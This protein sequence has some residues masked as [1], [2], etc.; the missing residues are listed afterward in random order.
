M[1][2]LLSILCLFI[3]S[4]DSGGDSDDLQDASIFGNWQ[5]VS[6]E[7]YDNADCSGTPFEIN[8]YPYTDDYQEVYS[9]PLF[10]FNSNYTYVTG[11]K[12]CQAE[13]NGDINIDECNIGVDQEFYQNPYSIQNIED[14]IFTNEALVLEVLYNDGWGDISL[15]F[16]FSNNNELIFYFYDTDLQYCDKIFLNRSGIDLN[17]YEPVIED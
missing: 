13:N 14:N 8:Y 17:D 9:Q 3:F 11:E 5:Y 2:Y 1:K 16:I 6:Y 15:P 4:C 10:T 12:E 7:N